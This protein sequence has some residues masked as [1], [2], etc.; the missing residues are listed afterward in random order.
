[1]LVRDCHTTTPTRWITTVLMLSSGLGL[2]A[3]A[4]SPEPHPSVPVPPSDA[5]AT[6]IED[7]LWDRVLARHPD[8]E[9]PTETIVRYVDRTEWAPTIAQCMLDAGFDAEA[10]PDGL[11]AVNADGTGQ[12]EAQAV[13]LFGCSV[14]YP[15]E[16]KYTDPFTDDQLRELYQYQTTELTECLTG[17]GVDVRPAPSLEV[18]VQTH[19]THEQWSPYQ[20]L[21]NSRLTS[22]QITEIRE[23]CPELPE[24]IY[25]L[26]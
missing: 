2:V 8:A 20:D 1:M 11:L 17:N 15:L 24:Y 12:D 9:R 18:F 6:S 16:L 13:A 23:I 21:P 3:C 14:R 25:D 19:L 7:Q 22:E 10:K 26:R 4:S 5:S